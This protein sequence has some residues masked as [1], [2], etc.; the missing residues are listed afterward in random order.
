MLTSQ[1]LSEKSLYPAT[2]IVLNDNMKSAVPENATEQEAGPAPKAS[3]F[4][5]MLN[6]VGQY[7]DRKAFIDLFEYF[8][9][10]IKSFMLKSGATPDQA[11]ELAQETMLTVWNKAESYNPK[12][13]AASTWIFT[14]ARNK[15][16]DGIRKQSRPEPDPDDPLMVRDDLPVPGETLSRDEETGIVSEAMKDLP[17]EQADLIRKAFF[18]DK[19]HQA[20]A[21]ETKLPLGTVKSRI[22]LALDRLRSNQ[23]VNELWT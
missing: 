7:K 13:A 4:E 18:E 8:A 17:E 20:I 19:T 9:P 22:R 1:K 5:D 12:L 3:S 14:I 16:I 11:D 23:K 15:R 21:D 2:H 10:R 6:A